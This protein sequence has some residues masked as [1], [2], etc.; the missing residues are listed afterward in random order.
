MAARVAVIEKCALDSIRRC[1]GI[2]M[3]FNPK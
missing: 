3:N 1:I 2:P